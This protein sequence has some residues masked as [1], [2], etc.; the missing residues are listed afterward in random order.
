[1][2]ISLSCC[3]LLLLSWSSELSLNCCS[4]ILVLFWT[5][6]TNEILYALFQIRTESLCITLRLSG[7]PVFLSKMP[8]SL[9]KSWGKWWIY[10]L[11]LGS[12][13]TPA[14]LKH[15]LRKPYL[16]EY[17]GIF[18]AIKF[19]IMTFPQT[20]NLSQQLQHFLLY[21]ICTYKYLEWL[22]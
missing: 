10:K 8:A 3:L 9:N 6:L 21:F 22:S 15:C 5:T 18:L 7:M 17:E 2:S 13:I 19:I 12:V 20:L 1:M 4:P 11:A 16:Q 14:I